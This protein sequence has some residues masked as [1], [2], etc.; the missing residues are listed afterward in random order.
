M[1]LIGEDEFVQFDDTSAEDDGQLGLLDDH[2]ADVFLLAGVETAE[3]V[4][5]GILEAG[6]S[7]FSTRGEIGEGSEFLRAEV[8][9]VKITMFFFSTSERYIT[10]NELIRDD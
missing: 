9:T 5:L 1:R 10:Y 3:F 7:R 4:V 2:V 8:L 6:S